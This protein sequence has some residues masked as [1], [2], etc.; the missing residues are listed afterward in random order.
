MISSS[1]LMLLL[2]ITCIAVQK[3]THSAPLPLSPFPFSL[4][5][6]GWGK[7]GVFFGGGGGGGGVDRALQVC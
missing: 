2:L 6:G 4:P 7:L 3:M 1:A 5:L